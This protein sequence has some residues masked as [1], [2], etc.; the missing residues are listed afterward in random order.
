[1]AI[2]PP[3]SQAGLALLAI[4]S[5]QA[6]AQTIV[7]KNFTLI[8]G[9]GRPVR[10]GVAMLVRDGQ[11]RSIRPAAKVRKP[12]RAGV[13][14]LAGKI[15]MPGLIN[16]HGHVGATV[17]LAQGPRFY[18]RTNVKR[19]LATYASY[20]VTAVLSLGTDLDPIYSV[21]EEERAG[22][23]PGMARV[24]TAGMG[25]V[26]KGAFPA[27][28]GMRYEVSTVAECNKRVDELAAKQ[29][30]IVKIWVDDHFGRGRK[31]PIELSR[32]IIARAHKHGLRVAV[33]IVNLSDAKELIAAGA[34]VL[35]HSVRDQPV[36]QEL[37]GMM[38]KRHVWQIA[39]LTR[40]ISTY[41]Y[42]ERPKFLDEPFF[43]RGVS[44]SV[45]ETLKSR[46]YIDRLKADPDFPRYPNL[47]VMAKQNLKRL[48]DAGVKIGF[49]TDSGPPARFPGYFEQWELELMVEAGLTPMQVITAATK[50][51]AQFLGARELGTLARGKQ[52]DFL[53]LSKN[54][55]DDIR[56]TRSIESVYIAGNLVK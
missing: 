14:D 9:T 28:G 19:N 1:M 4:V 31:T 2:S 18:T 49:G 33:H 30:D 12:R 6:T 36:D 32:A 8:D 29:V 42:A 17:D 27:A 39:T 37:I 22:A 13:I 35:A 46:P 23:K 44:A 20:G 16:L 54:P 43:T 47:L 38:K 10:P 15:V 11:I 3:P 34:D 48:A 21:R 7:F 41:I 25:F 52:A 24:Y 56:N 50:S 51:S 55:L 40:E 53:V 26:G 5:I 45:I